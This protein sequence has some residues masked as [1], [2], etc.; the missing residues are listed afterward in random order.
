MNLPRAAGVYG[1]AFLLPCGLAAQ[2]SAPSAP[3]P[4]LVIAEPIF[5]FGEAAP[6][7]ALMHDF[8]IRNDGDA[9]LL[10]NDVIAGCACTTAD[11]DREIAPGASSTIHAVLDTVSLVGPIAK[12]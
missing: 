8:A 5:D 9:V 11:F 6:G 12:Q 4:H 2:A 1:L 7:A 10:V 3:Q